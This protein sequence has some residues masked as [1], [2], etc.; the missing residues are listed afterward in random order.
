MKRVNSIDS[1][2]MLLALDR[3][4]YFLARNLCPQ[5][6]LGIAKSLGD[7]RVD[8]RSP[9]SIRTIRPQS[10]AEAKPNTL[11]SR[12]GMGRFPFHTDVAHWVEPAQFVLL[13][14]E[15]PGSGARPTHL[16]DFLSWDLGAEAKQSALREVWKTGTFR[17]QLCTVCILE[18]GRV[19]LRFDEAC[20]KAMTVAAHTLGNDLVRHIQAS[21]IIDVHWS[22]GTMLVVDNRRVLHARGTALRPDPDRLINRV[23]IGGNT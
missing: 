10:T 20:M 6:I 11:S 5:E 22:T 21:P 16:Q 3:A 13:Y 4:G 18:K 15:H 1:N 14:C 23:L 8:V 12:Y 19:A 2:E 7:I 9:Q 17:P